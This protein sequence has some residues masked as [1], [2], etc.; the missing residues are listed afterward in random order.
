VDFTTVYSPSTIRRSGRWMVRFARAASSGL[1]VVER[2]GETEGRREGG[3]EGRRD[4]ERGR[5]GEG[6][7]K[8]G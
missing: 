5:G 7:R 6:E 1:G 8:P 2:D 4:E 3:T